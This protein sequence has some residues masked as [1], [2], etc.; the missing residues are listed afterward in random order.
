VSLLRPGGPFGPL[1][2]GF[3][4]ME[5]AR[6]LT[7]SR[8]RAEL[9]HYRTKDKVEVDAI[10]EN[11]Q[12]N[13]AGIEVKASS[14]VSPEDF[15]GLRQGRALD[16]G[17]GAPD[18]ALGLVRLEHVGPVV[19]AAKVLDEPAEHLAVEPSDGSGRINGNPG[20]PGMGGI[21]A[22]QGWEESHRFRS[23][24][25]ASAVRCTA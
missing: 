1:L 3:V 12:G 15:R 20:Q 9:F 7:W 11:R 22:V 6:Q 21:P 19:V 17:L 13:V 25:V 14:T 18:G 8:Q 23:K 4:L 2:E 10:L 16:Q 5:L 24:R